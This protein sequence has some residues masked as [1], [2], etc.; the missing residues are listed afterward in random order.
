M[1]AVECPY[2]HPR[3]RNRTQQL[4]NI[5]RGHLL[6]HSA[7]KQFS[8][9]ACVC[10]G[11]TCMIAATCMSYFIQ[12]FL[13]N[14]EKGR[15][16]RVLH[17]IPDLSQWIHSKPGS[18]PP[19]ARSILEKYL[20]TASQQTAEQGVGL[21]GVVSLIYQATNGENTVLDIYAQY[22]LYPQ[23]VK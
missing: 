4:L 9:T 23:Y 12:A 8:S 3:W 18:I 13:Q 22:R 15:S 1:T 21:V 7:A 16:P 5:L 10:P 19:N 17:T 6:S 2:H 11:K 14:V 20:S